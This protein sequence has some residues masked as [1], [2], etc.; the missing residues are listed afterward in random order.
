MNK[1]TMSNKEIVILLI[2][3]YIG[4]IINHFQ[5]WMFWS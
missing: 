4:I 3:L 5:V 2:G 1:I